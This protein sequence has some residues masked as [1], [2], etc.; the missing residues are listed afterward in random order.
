MAYR[1]ADGT[2]VDDG[3]TAAREFIEPPP[4]H[5]E[6]WDTGHFDGEEV[7]GL[8]T[9]TPK[10]GPKWDRKP[11]AGQTGETQTFKGWNN[12]D[13]KIEIRTWTRAQ[14]DDFI[15]RILPIIEP[16]PGKE[17]PKEVGIDH[18]IARARKIESFRINDIEGPKAEFDKGYTV[19]T[20]D[21]FQALKKVPQK[22]GGGGPGQTPCQQC[23]AMT[24]QK[25]SEYNQ[26]LNDYN[27]GKDPTYN[28]A[29]VQAAFDAW[30]NQA[31]ICHDNNCDNQSPDEEAHAEGPPAPGDDDNL[32]GPGGVV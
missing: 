3:G 11:V 20:I 30:Q 7:P 2:T 1:A 18:P 23:K 5:T 32:R 6:N 14:Y 27:A 8:M 28:Y 9:M 31:N 17:A 16:E 4:W 29:P 25:L 19:W 15:S 24:D 10:R 26:K 21:A 13:F 12:A 22:G